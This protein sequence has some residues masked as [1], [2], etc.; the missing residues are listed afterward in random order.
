L[1]THLPRTFSNRMLRQSGRLPL[2]GPLDFKPNANRGKELFT[3]ELRF[4]W[5]E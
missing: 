1:I 3:C 4:I 2:M 5:R